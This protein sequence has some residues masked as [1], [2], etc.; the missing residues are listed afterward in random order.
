MPD[1]YETILT[2]TRER[3]ALIRLN[4]PKQLNALNDTLMRELGAALAAYDAD[5]GI[6]AIVLTGS[7]RAFAGASPLRSSHG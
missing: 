4:R 5:D 2:E 1:S 3:V 6:G 7:D